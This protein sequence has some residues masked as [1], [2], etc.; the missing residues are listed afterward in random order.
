M[1][2]GGKDKRK[3]ESRSTQ[4]FSLSKQVDGRQGSGDRRSALQIG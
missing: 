2:V 1:E 3:K 4:V